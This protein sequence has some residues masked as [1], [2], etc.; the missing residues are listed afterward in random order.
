MKRSVK[1]Y[2]QTAKLGAVAGMRSMVA[3]SLLSGYLAKTDPKTLQDTPL[4][5][6]KSPAASA[7]LKLAAAGEMLADKMP[8]TP[9]RI[10]APPLLWRV[11]WGTLSGV[12][13]TLSRRRPHPVRAA[14]VGGGAALLTTYAAYYLRVQ[15]AER[16]HIPDVVLG[17][18]EDA[19]VLAL[20]A[21]LAEDMA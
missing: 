3:I 20:R 5:L 11:I 15:A 14:L 12:V 17:M 9:A 2:I 19:A 4:A 21:N 1:T 8:F 6:L 16:L 7:A 13:L 18:A 10:A